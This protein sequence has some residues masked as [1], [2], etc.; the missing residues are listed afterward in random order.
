MVGLKKS[1]MP[2]RRIT[3][4]AGDAARRGGANAAA[5]TR[6]AAITSR[7][8]M[9]I[10]LKIPAITSRGLDEARCDHES[11]EDLQNEM[12]A[13]VFSDGWVRR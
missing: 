9:P 5:S 13:Q 3:V 7:C 8:P 1:N 10:R 6:H 12:G 2:M 4:E 11:S